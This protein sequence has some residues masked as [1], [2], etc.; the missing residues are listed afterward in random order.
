MNIYRYKVLVDR[1]QDIIPLL[2]PQHEEY[3]KELL[4]RYVDKINQYN[5]NNKVLINPTKEELGRW[6]SCCLKV[7]RSYFNYEDFK[8]E[9][10]NDDDFFIDDYIRKTPF[11]NSLMQSKLFLNRH[12]DCYKPTILESAINESIKIDII[13]EFRKHNKQIFKTK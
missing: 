7:I 1:L 3:F 10:A 5:K 9:F 6:T 12:W 8:D 11:S 2:E 4:K 13:K